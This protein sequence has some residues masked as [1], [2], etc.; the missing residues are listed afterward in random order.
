VLWVPAF[1]DDLEVRFMAAHNANQNVCLVL[2]TEVSTKA[3]LSILNRFH[4]FTS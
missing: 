2:F 3:A 1:V 4:I